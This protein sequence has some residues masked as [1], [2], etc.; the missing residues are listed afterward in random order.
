MCFCRVTVFSKISLCTFPK[1]AQK[2]AVVE[3]THSRVS[4]W[5]AKQG[6]AVQGHLFLSPLRHDPDLVQHS[7][8][9]CFKVPQTR[10][11]A[12]VRSG[13]TVFKYSYNNR[14]RWPRG[15][16]P[17]GQGHRKSSSPRRITDAKPALPGR[18]SR[19]GARGGPRPPGRPRGAPGLAS[20]RPAPAPG[21]GDSALS[22][23]RPWRGRGVLPHRCAAS[24]RPAPRA[25]GLAFCSKWMVPCTGP[26][27]FSTHTAFIAMLP[28]KTRGGLL[29]R[30]QREQDEKPTD[31][32]RRR[33]GPRKKT[34]PWRH[35]A[36]IGLSLTTPT[37]ARNQ[38][39]PAAS[40]RPSWSSLAA[41]HAGGGA[42]DSSS[43]WSLRTEKVPEEPELGKS[44][45]SSNCDVGRVAAETENTRPACAPGRSEPTVS[46]NAD[47]H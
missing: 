6:T 26:S 25:P 28:R 5:S 10:P 34:R 17:V 30:D 2:L 23:L 29:R 43:S 33:K 9:L 32:R 36:F 3:N 40:A 24:P 27:P 37:L 46:G 11:A 7:P 38:S 12:L 8:G 31:G 15:S 13:T 45:L 1:C 35:G 39:L 47:C 41:G 22:G 44:L 16:E 14:S 42:E 21:H 19:S 4:L 18:P 20:R